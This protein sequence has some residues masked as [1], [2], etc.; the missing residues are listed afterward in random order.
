M[1]AKAGLLGDLAMIFLS[2]D[3]FVRTDKQH[4]F[5]WVEWNFSIVAPFWFG[6]VCL[7]AQS[8][9]MPSY[10]FYF[11]MFIPNR[12]FLSVMKVSTNRSTRTEISSY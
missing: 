3:F 11:T 2:P 7:A 8:K 9:P 12:K 4:C 10:K 6:L 5:G 1:P